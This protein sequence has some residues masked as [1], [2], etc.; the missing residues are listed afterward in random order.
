[1]IYHLTAS[2]DAYV[3]NKIVNGTSRATTGNTGYASTID[4]FKLYGE[5]NILNDTSVQ[6][7]LSRGLIQFDLAHLSSSIMSSTGASLTE[8]INN[9]ALKIKLQLSDVQG[10]QVAPINFQL[11]LW[12]LDQA[13]EEG[14]GDNVVTFGDEF[15]ASWT[16]AETGTNWVNE[17]AWKSDV[18]WTG[19]SAGKTYIDRQTF[20]T[21]EE[22]L[23]L[24]VTEWVKAL[25]DSGNSTVGTNYGWVLKFN[26]TQEGNT[27][28]YFVKRFASRHTR[29]PFLRPKLI[30]SW[31]D[32][33]IDERLDFYANTDSSKLSIKN[34]SRSTATT[35][36]TGVYL[37]LLSGSFT[38]SNI[39]ASKVTIEGKERDHF[40]EVSTNIDITSTY[41][42]LATNLIATG[43]LVMEE[44]WY[45]S[46]DVLVHSGSFILKNPLATSNP[47]P[48]DYRFS[49]VDL[50]STYTIDDEPVIRLFIRDRNLANEPVR[51]PIQLQSQII[52]K[53]YYQIKDTNSEQILIP[54]SDTATDSDESTRVSAD[55]QGM[56][57]KFPASVLPRGRTYTIDI[58]YY[59]RGER[60]VHEFN[61]AF[62]IK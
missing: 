58:A 34:Y 9:S 40:Y 22:N 35:L 38:S 12:P 28:S 5:S 48:R 31:E 23:E 11:E 24:D 50:K 30:A 41:S 15:P 21:G 60:R 13:W 52:N 19:S 18:T 25:W 3:T 53:V 2:K 54:F 17:G 45:N 49:I 42:D 43:S 39:P 37:K 33:Y 16:V 55:G 4:M 8:I 1:M 59:D 36:G 51:I 47:G 46:A 32:Y 56:H 20:V 27:A 61:K 6:T 29:N 57:F 14:L 62:R 7:E 44:R 26:S 10:T